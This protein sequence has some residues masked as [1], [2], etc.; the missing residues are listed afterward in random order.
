MTLIP[1]FRQA[2]NLI[3][4]PS[5]QSLFLF[6]APALNLLFTDISIL[7]T[8]TFFAVKQGHWQAF[9]GVLSAQSILVLP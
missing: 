1:A 2:V 8:L 5:Y 6:M 9:G 7:N 4:I 3:H